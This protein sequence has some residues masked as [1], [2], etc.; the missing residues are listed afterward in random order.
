[1]DEIRPNA[2]F[3]N[4]GAAATAQ[5]CQQQSAA[6]NTHADRLVQTHDDGTGR[7]VVT[8]RYTEADGNAIYQEHLALWKSAFGERRSPPGVPQPLSFDPLV[9][10]VTMEHIPGAPLAVR[11]TLGDTLEQT[12]RVAELLADLH[13]SGVPLSRRRST[14]AVVRSVQRKAA[15]LPAAFAEFRRL[16]DRLA[17]CA[18]VDDQYVVSHGDFSPRNVLLTPETQRLTIIDFDRL[19]SASPARDVAY[20]G[21]WIWTTQ[22]LCDEEASW[23]P[24]DQ[25]AAAYL[26]CAPDKTDAVTS[27]L[28]FHRAAALARIVHGWSALAT[29]DDLARRLIDDAMLLIKSP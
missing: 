23:L 8:K 25:F 4:R 29:R 1:M 21:A 2:T 5:V 13:S 14:A 11:G 6:V 10:V 16:A 26:R 20:W 3:G 27:H 15:S 28:A 19:Q 7:R 17:A 9:G 12:H 24:G 22:R 18:P